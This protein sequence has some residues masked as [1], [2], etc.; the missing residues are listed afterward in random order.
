MN[1]LTV[2]LATLAGFALATFA[3]SFASAAPADHEYTTRAV[4]SPNGKDVFVRIVKV[5]KMQATAE[6]RDCPMD[7]AHCT[8]PKAH[9]PEAQG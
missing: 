4:R 1:F 2:P 6:K 3:S 9:K 7:P 5:P 8:R